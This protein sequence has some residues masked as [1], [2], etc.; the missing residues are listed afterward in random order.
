MTDVETA[1]KNVKQILE[2]SKINDDF[3]TNGIQLLKRGKKGLLSILFSRTGIVILLLVLQVALITLWIGSLREYMPHYMVFMGILDAFMA[4]LVINSPMDSTAKIT[5]LVIISIL[6]VFGALFFLY[7]WTNLGHRKLKQRVEDLTEKEKDLI[8]QDPDVLREVKEISP[9]TAG[10]AHYIRRTGCY[11]IYN[12]T[13]VRYFPMGEDMLET[14]LWE[15]DKAEDFIFLEYF[16]INEGI[17]WGKIL[18]ILARKVQEGVDVRVIYDGTCEITK[19]SS[20][21]PKRLEK[22]GIKCRV[23][24]PLRP[25][26]STHYNYRDHRKIMVIDGKTAFTG[27]VNLA[28]EYIN[29][30]EKFGKWKDTALMIKGEA[31]KSFTLLFLSAWNL[32]GTEE[33]YLKYLSVPAEIPKNTLGYVMPYGDNPLDQDKVGEFVYMDI[34]NHASRFVHIMTPYLILDD[35]LTAALKL[36]ASRGVDVKL[37][38]PGIP[39]KAIPYA[40]AKGHYMTLLRAGVKIYEYTPGFV[41]AKVFVSDDVRAVVGT[42]NLDYRSLYHHFECATYLYRTACIPDIEDDFQQTLRQCR[43]VTKKMVRSEKLHTKITCVLVK[44]IAPLL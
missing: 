32:T 29:E 3:N 12:N 23:F 1:D 25:F 18:E 38:L 11:P 28:D 36:A 41:H 7:C 14:M 27:G 13:D 19:L 26:V 9:E 22:L 31:V 44:A 16:I 40:L 21:Y 6:P 33:S 4:I 42:I 37:I 2:E 24:S 17:M 20:D 15:L 34:L 10:M 39:D 5:W 8:I 30:L 43:K 35:E